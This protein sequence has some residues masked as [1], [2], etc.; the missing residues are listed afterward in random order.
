MRAHIVL[1]ATG[2]LMLILFIRALWFYI[3]RRTDFCQYLLEIIFEKIRAIH[4]K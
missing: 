1:A 4:Y 2:V 3:D